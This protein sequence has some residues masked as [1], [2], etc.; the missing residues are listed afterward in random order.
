MGIENECEIEYTADMAYF[1]ASVLGDGS[2]NTRNKDYTISFSSIDKE[3]FDKIYLI[4]NRLI[5]IDAQRDKK[6]LLITVIQPTGKARQPRFSVSTHSKDLCEWLI[7][8]THNKRKIPKFI[9][10]NSKFLKYFLGGI[11]D[12]EG[13]ICKRK[14][15]YSIDVGMKNHSL[16]SEI[17]CGFKKLDIRVSKKLNFY[18]STN[19]SRQYYFHINTIDFVRA[20][21]PLVIKRKKNPLRNIRK[22]KKQRLANYKLIASELKRV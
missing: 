20:R 6:P 17:Y 8:E 19:N 2:F 18:R 1:I 5:P 7:K 10:E 21:I 12:S 13:S 16:M 14:F 9:K 11:I 22:K 15:E 4:L 3:Y